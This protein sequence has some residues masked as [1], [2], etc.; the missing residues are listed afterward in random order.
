MQEW[1]VW[2]VSS[3]NVF[4]SVLNIKKKSLCFL[5]WA[6]SN[7]FWLIYDLYSKSYARSILDVV[8]LAM[9]IL[10]MISWIKPKEKS[11]PTP[12]KNT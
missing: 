1:I 10:G 6:L 4:G 7:V 12:E 9:N 8:N 5:L 2:M 3:V 11:D